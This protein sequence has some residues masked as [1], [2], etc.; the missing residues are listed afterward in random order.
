[1]A[2]RL[3]ERLEFVRERNYSLRQNMEEYQSLMNAEYLR[4]LILSVRFQHEL[5]H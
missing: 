4:N 5:L 1:M 3:A 2:S